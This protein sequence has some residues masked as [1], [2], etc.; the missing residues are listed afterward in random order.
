MNATVIKKQ[1][2]DLLLLID[3]II[4]LNWCKA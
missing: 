1:R 3:Y 4:D 2:I